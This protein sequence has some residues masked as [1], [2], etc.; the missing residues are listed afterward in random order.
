MPT[1][2]LLLA[3]LIPTMRFFLVFFLLYGGI[4]AY[5]AHALIH[6]FE[7]A[8]AARLLTY[9]LALLMTLSPLLL[10]QLERNTDNHELVVTAAWIVFGWMGFVFVFFWL[11]LALNLYDLGARSVGLPMPAARPAFLAL[12]V[13]TAVLWV[14]GF[15]S[16]WHPR[17]ERVSIHSDKL[18]PGFPG[19]RIVQISDL[20]LGMLIGRHRL[21][22]ILGQIQPLQ[23]DLLIST[24]D[25]LDAQAEY[26]DGLSSRFA[27]LHPRYGKFAVTGNHERYVGLEHALD[28]HA[29]SGFRLLRGETVEV[30]GVLTLAGVD[31][32]AV[33]AGPTGEA[34]LL[35]RIPADRF[36]LLLKHQPVISAGARFDLQLSGHTHDGQIFPFGYMVRLLYPIIEGLNP[37]PAGGQL[38]VSRGTG[39]WGPPIRIFAP[40]EIT[41]IELNMPA[42]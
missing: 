31:D 29:R 21:D 19:L 3:T 12:S 34:E 37:L 26:V 11:G 10:R 16:A 22:H 23:P 18:P 1:Q 36:V 32:P 40:A 35:A 20:H 33:L 4:Q 5:F 8:R 17:V 30:A 6:A 42:R 7:L 14:Y 25:L 2:I 28:F 41:L 9:C 24:G 27:S 39:T 38:Y 15:Y 13:A